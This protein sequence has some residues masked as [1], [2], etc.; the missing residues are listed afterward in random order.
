MSSAWTRVKKRLKDR[1][2]QLPLSNGIAD[3]QTFKAHALGLFG[4]GDRFGNA[5]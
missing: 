5:L 1:I 2:V 4:N 3:L